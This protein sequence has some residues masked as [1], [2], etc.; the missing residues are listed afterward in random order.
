MPC[1]RHGVVAVN[2]IITLLSYYH[3]LSQ[4]VTIAEL[5]ITC[6]NII[7]HGT[8]ELCSLEIQYVHVVINSKL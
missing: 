3:H 4:R 8:I 6:V 2:V 5:K 7:S 1:D